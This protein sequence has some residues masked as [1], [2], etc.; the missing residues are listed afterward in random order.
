[1]ILDL[2]RLRMEYAKIYQVDEGSARREPLGGS[3]SEPSGLINASFLC[4]TSLVSNRWLRLFIPSPLLLKSVGYLHFDFFH[5]VAFL[6][7]YMKQRQ[8]RSFEDLVYQGVTL[9]AV[10]PVV[11]FVV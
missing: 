6:S 1:M 5:V 4:L 9:L 7:L 11:A 3:L 10:R 8:T 2:D